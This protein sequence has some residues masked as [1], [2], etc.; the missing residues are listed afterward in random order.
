VSLEQVL[1]VHHERFLRF[2]ARRTGNRA[3]A[4]DVLHAAYLRVLRLE[5]PEGEGAVRWFQ[6]VLRNALV[7]AA[8]RRGVEERA[9]EREAAEGPAAVAPDELDAAVCACVLDVLPAVKPEYAALLRAVDLEGR[10]VA[11]AAAEQSITPN[12]ASVRLH[13]ARQALRQQLLRVCGACAAHGCLDC[14]CR[15]TH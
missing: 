4:E 6:R 10:A 5:L 8:R 7:D 1:L 2:V 13:R 11:D 15:A 9:L 14:G 3:D 12:N